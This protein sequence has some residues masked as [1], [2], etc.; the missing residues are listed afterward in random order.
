MF[1]KNASNILE[2][3][4][5]ASRDASEYGLSY[6]VVHESGTSLEE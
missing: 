5:V 3:I 4:N 2:I 1:K 6:A